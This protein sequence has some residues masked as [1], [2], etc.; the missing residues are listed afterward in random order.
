MSEERDFDWVLGKVPRHNQDGDD[1]SDDELGTGGRRR[2]DGKL[3]GLAYDLEYYDPDEAEDDEDEMNESS[4][5]PSSSD[6][7]AEGAVVGAV[8]AI[9]VYGAYRAI[10]W[11]VPKV[12]NKSQKAVALLKKKLHPE[13][14]GTENEVIEARSEPVASTI[15]VPDFSDLDAAYEEYHRDMSNEEI[16]RHLINIV[17]YYMAIMNELKQL[18]DV[19]V[20]RDDWDSAIKK[21]VASDSIEVLN[22]LIGS[23][24]ALLGD[25]HAQTLSSIL[26]REMIVEGKYVPIYQ[27]ELEEAFTIMT[28]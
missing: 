11:A 25:T 19:R 14:V 4:E 3:A 2:E 10:K 24:P 13:A 5:L 18:Q 22:Q 9:V 6:R 23:N 7:F 28:W 16:Q 8:L 20:T 21:L 26:N 27:S 17:V 15:V 1:I 12:K